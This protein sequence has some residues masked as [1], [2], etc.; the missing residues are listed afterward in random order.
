MDLKKHKWYYQEESP[1]YIESWFYVLGHSEYKGMPQIKWLA[2]INIG[3]YLHVTDEYVDADIAGDEEK[4][5]TGKQAL[6]L[7]ALIFQ[8]TYISNDAGL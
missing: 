4:P 5:M 1:E 2:F 6:R 3:S 7:I 8:A